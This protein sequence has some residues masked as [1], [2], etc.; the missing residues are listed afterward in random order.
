M[1]KF[2]LKARTAHKTCREHIDSLESQNTEI[3]SYLTEHILVI[4]CANV[5]Q[6]IYSIIEARANK[7]G[8]DQ[9]KLYSIA[10][11]KRVLRSVL[12]SEVTG[13]IGN[14]GEDAKKYFTDN[15]D[16]RKMIIY[17]NAVRNRHKTAHTSNATVTFR[18]IDDIIESAEHLLEEVEEAINLEK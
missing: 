2:L 11:C 5:Q 3:E 17:N 1:S 10:T 4:L 16:E 7:S 12:Q 13:F 14:F 9:L 6:D 15:I 8:D 18:E